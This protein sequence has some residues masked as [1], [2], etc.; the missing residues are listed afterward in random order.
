MCAV[1]VIRQGPSTKVIISA[2]PGLR[3]IQTC[4]ASSIARL[5]LRCYLE[6]RVQF[7]KRTRGVDPRESAYY[8]VSLFEERGNV[9]GEEI[10]KS[11]KWQNEWRRRTLGERHPCTETCTRRRDAPQGRGNRGPSRRAATRDTWESLGDACLIHDLRSNCS[12]VQ[13]R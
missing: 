13:F 5:P 8:R 6:S 11:E 1:T 12:R 2:C 7:W 3:L 9:R 10:E 4:D